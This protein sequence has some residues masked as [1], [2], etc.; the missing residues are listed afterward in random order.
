MHIS[1]SLKELIIKTKSYGTEHYLQKAAVV[2]ERKGGTIRAVNS[3]LDYIILLINGLTITSSYVLPL[4]SSSLQVYFLLISQEYYN[5]NYN[6]KLQYQLQHEILDLAKPF[7]LF[8][9]PRYNLDSGLANLF[10]LAL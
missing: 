8:N 2:S 1:A 4:N 6:M 9:F 3:T 5:I 10:I 7:I